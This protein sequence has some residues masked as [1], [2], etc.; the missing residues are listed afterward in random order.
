MRP[1]GRVWR[2]SRINT[3]MHRIVAPPGK[4]LTKASYKLGAKQGALRYVRV[5]CHTV[6]VSPWEDAQHRWAWS[7]PIYLE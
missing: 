3:L 5:A 6:P 1:G 2:M 4:T 7:N